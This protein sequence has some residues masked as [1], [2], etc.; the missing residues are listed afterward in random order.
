MITTLDYTI[1]AYAE[2]LLKNKIGSLVAIEPGTGEI[3]ALVS[4]PGY[5]PNLFVGRERGNNYMKLLRDPQKPLFNRALSAPYTPGSIFKVID[6]LIAQQ[7]GVIHPE[8]RF[9]C[10]GGYRLGNHTVKCT[11]VHSPLDLRQSLQLSCNP[12]YCAVFRSIIDKPAFHSARNGYESWYNHLKSF[13]IGR[14]LEIDLAHEYPGILKSPAY[15]DKVYGAGR[16]KSTNI[17][18]LAIGQGEVG[19]TPCRWPMWLLL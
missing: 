6:A 8:T 1:Q 4:T 5:D 15:F 17:I 10:G 14:R 2:E 13:G 9:P 19:I 18:S 16:W 3:L 7:E 12:Y 11:H